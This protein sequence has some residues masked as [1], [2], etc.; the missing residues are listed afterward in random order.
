[1]CPSVLVPVS[2][3]QMAFPSEMMTVWFD[4]ET[5]LPQLQAHKPSVVAHSCVGAFTEA[6]GLDLIVS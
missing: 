5:F 4:H 3:A 1:M 2:F 6:G